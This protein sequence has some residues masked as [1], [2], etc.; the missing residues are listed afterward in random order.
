MHHFIG[1]AGLAL[2]HQHRHNTMKILIF[3]S[4][5]TGFCQKYDSFIKQIKNF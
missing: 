4:K 2:E 5:K 1:L 3:I